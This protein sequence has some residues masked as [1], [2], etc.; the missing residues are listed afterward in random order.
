MTA[1]RAADVV[2]VFDS[3]FRQV[4][5]EARTLKATVKEE[6]K[7]MEHPL[8]DGSS[9]V[10][11]KIILPIEVDLSVIIQSADFRSVYD[12]IKRYYLGA[13]L[14]SVQTRTGVYNSMVIQ[15]MPHDESPDM[16]DT[17]AI[18]L[19]LKE[20]KLVTAQF[21][22]LPPRKVAKPES[23]STVKRGEQQ[24]QEQT[25]AKKTSVLGGLFQ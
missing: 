18:A 5:P 7:V 23:S 17:V 14:L 13:E 12:Q 2:G 1:T 21:G 10:D 25:P 24:P 8:E 16:L 22:T 6:A 11:H 20:V 4:F 19:K 15:S 3:N 9:I